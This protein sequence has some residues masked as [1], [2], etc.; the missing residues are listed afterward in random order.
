MEPLPTRQTLAEQMLAYQP[1]AWDAL[2]DL[3]LYMD[4]VIT[5]LERQ[6]SPFHPLGIKDRIITPAMINNY[7]KMRVIPRPVSKKYERGHLAALLMLCTL[8]Q[9]LPM[10]AIG[11]LLANQSEDIRVGYEAFC[12]QQRAAFRQVSAALASVETDALGCAVQAS[13]LCL[14]AETLLPPAREPENA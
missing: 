1:P 4:Q 12:A 13:A 7:V 9:V 8:K 3:G 14:A 6:L 5:F 10:D 2:P 11:R